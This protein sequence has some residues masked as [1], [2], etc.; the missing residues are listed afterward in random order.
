MASGTAA[1]SYDCDCG[2]RDIIRHGENG[3]LVSGVGDTRKL[4]ESLKTLMQSDAKRQLLASR[5]S[6]VKDSF[7]L[8]TALSLWRAAFVAAGVSSARGVGA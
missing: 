2:P 5:A 3:L 7:S 1:V 6:G 4:A 8:E